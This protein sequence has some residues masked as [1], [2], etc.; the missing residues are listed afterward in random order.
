MYIL[1]TDTHKEIKLEILRRKV[2]LPST[3]SGSQPTIVECSNCVVLWQT[4]FSNQKVFPWLMSS[5]F[6]LYF[7]SVILSEQCPLQSQ[8]NIRSVS[9]TLANESCTDRKNKIN[10]LSRN[11]QSKLQQ[12]FWIY[13]DHLLGD[14]ECLNVWIKD[15]GYVYCL[16]IDKDFVT[17]LGCICR[18]DSPA[19]TGL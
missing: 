15:T 7:G 18:E 6:H 14:Q 10:T 13:S 3:Y 8:L 12:L 11:L 5:I 16:K 17:E 2:L 9:T 1:N 4:E 19:F